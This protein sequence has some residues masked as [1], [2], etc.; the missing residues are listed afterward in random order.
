M[1]K[2]ID[3]LKYFHGQMLAMAVGV[4]VLVH[5]SFAEFDMLSNWG[6]EQ[7]EGVGFRQGNF[8]GDD[9]EIVVTDSSWDA[10]VKKLA[11]VGARENLGVL[12]VYDLSSGQP[13]TSFSWTAS[14]TDLNNSTVTAVTWATDD[15]LIL[16]AEGMNF[17]AGNRDPKT[18]LI[19]YI[20]SEDKISSRLIPWQ[21]GDDLQKDGD[22]VWLLGVHEVK[23]AGVQQVNFSD[24]NASL[25]GKFHELQ[26]VKNPTSLVVEG[27]NLWVGGQDDFVDAV[28]E[29]AGTGI[30]IPLPTSYISSM[31]QGKGNSNGSIFVTGR[32]RNGK[33][34]IF[35]ESFP[36][37]IKR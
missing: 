19:T 21:T 34:D 17:V 13:E 15:K 31:V 30:S 1:N 29:I 35:L 27:G 2:M 5:S 25:T 16:V 12:R 3:R 9:A 20:R 7:G 32:A 24:S 11:V 8:V 28:I 14:E 22:K 10:S 37:K 4:G 36:L 23:G 33:E 6:F 18:Q 26:K